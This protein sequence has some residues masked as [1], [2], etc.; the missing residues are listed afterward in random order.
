MSMPTG[1]NPDPAG[2]PKSDPAGHTP[3]PS[4]GTPSTGPARY[5]RLA[6]G[7]CCSRL[8]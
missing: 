1:N 4:A 2:H 8:T 6:L 5:T 7:R 3:S